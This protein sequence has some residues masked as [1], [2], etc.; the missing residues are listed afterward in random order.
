MDNYNPMLNPGGNQYYP[1]YMPQLPPEAYQNAMYPPNEMQQAIPLPG[2]GGLPEPEPERNKPVAEQPPLSPAEPEQIKP[3]HKRRSKNEKA[4]RDY[5][6][7]C[8]KTYLSYPALYTHI[9]TKH[10][11]KNP[12]GTHQLPSGR[13]RGRPRKVC[14]FFA[15]CFLH[16]VF[17]VVKP[18]K[19]KNDH[20]HSR[21][22]KFQKTRMR[23]K[24][25]EK[26]RKLHHR[27]TIC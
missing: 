14:L 8:G 18:P 26:F 12:G 7:G 25:K 16:F 11:G 15:I 1:G 2:P 24:K 27:S 19:T 9:K 17:P 5:V 22:R 13:G 10:G 3:K 21:I 4:G 20:N 6:C 23:K